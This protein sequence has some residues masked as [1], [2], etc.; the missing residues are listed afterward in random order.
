MT[1][2][3]RSLNEVPALLEERRR[4]EAWIAALDA[5][6]DST[7]AHVFERVQSDYRNRLQQVA[8]RLATH[9]Q[10]IEEERASVQSRLS[11]LEA[12]EQMRRDER[13]ELDLRAHVGELA[14]SDADSAFG[15]VDDAITQLVG[16]KGGLQRRVA[17]LDALVA[18][19]P[20]DAASDEIEKEVP[21]L[22]ELI[23]EPA[24][25]APLEPPNAPAGSF[26]EMA[27][28]DAVVGKESANA[29]ASAPIEPP[30]YE[31]I[32]HRDEAD[33]ESLLAGLGGPR[34]ASEEA[35]LAANVPANTPIVLRPSGSIEQSKTLKCN[36]CG[37]MNYPTEW[38]C[39]RCGAELAAL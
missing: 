18:E 6:R 10:A 36:E 29:Q 20:A 23:D 2:P 22:E 15:T 9:R 7:P 13:A 39:E 16:E 11:L 4:Y 34:G 30:V 21:P 38:Y 32:I 26:D 27:F 8:D 28:L 19:R 33:S 3:N 25:V 31:R 17:E 35:P 12:E 5:R 14:G 1:D 24:Q 37:A